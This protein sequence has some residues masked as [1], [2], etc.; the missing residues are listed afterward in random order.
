MCQRKGNIRYEQNGE[1][2]TQQEPPDLL[3]FQKMIRAPRRDIVQESTTEE[4]HAYGSAYIYTT[5]Q[6]EKISA[7]IPWL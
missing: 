5:A 2:K 7:V 3:Q 6:I 4:C 1:N